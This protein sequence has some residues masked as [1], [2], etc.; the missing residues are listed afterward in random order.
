MIAKLILQKR[1]KSKLSFVKYLPKLFPFLTLLCGG[2]VI[3]KTV[4]CSFV[5]IAL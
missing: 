5:Q 3:Q 4:G 2:K 1:Q